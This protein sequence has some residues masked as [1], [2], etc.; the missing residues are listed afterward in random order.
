V[1]LHQ[2]TPSQQQILDNWEHFQPQTVKD[3][4]ARGQLETVLKS[5]DSLVTK[6]YADCI[7]KGLSVDQAE[8][9]TRP[10]WITPSPQLPDLPQGTTGF[11]RICR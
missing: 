10:M 8:E 7:Q 9:V 1:P 6:A 3:S 4:E 11:P 5:T 2:L